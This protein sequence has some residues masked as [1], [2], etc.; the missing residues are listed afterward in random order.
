[1]AGR[2][3]AT[4]R[5]LCSQKVLGAEDAKLLEL[6]ASPDVFLELT[7]GS[8]RETWPLMKLVGVLMPLVVKEG[9]RLLDK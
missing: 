1:M 2:A 8:G 3:Q 4:A 6:M 5:P 9:V 7:E